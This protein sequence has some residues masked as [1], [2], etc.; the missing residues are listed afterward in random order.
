MARRLQP[1]DLHER[2]DCF[3]EFERNDEV[4]LRLCGLHFECAATREHLTSLQ[5]RDES[6]AELG[7]PHSA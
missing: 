1:E 6:L 4:C 2:I 7:C 5:M 3:G